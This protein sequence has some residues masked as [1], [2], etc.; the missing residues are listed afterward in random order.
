V[1]LLAA[2]ASTPPRQNDQLEQARAEVEKFTQDPMAQQAA[3]NDVRTARDSLQQ[4]ET[5]LQQKKSPEEVNFLAYLAMRHAQAGEARVEEA[6]AQ[7]QVAQA[8]Q[9][10]NR[11]LLQSR[12]REAQNAKAQAQAAQ[13]QLQAR[14][15]ARGMVMTL[16]G[17][18]FDTGAA[19]LKPG[20]DRELD[21]LADYLEQNP[22]AR[23]KVEGF[24][25]N[26]GSDQANEQLSERRAQAVAEAL[27]QRGVSEDRVQ[28][29]GLGKEYP[30]ASNDSAAGRQENRR[31]EVVIS[32]QSG[33]FAE[34]AEP[35]RR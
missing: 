9:E 27:R 28:A 7:Q 20:A 2:C 6:R 22:Q 25:D 3:G 16:S 30:V 29:R 32:D 4:A 24:T 17:V 11:I 31:V 13:Q 35:V 33:R 10:R 18:L 14:N 12:E 21:R 23:V 5:A 26:R 15:T 1:I 34:E 19:T 8:E